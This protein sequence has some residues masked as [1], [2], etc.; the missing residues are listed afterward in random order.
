M[1]RL[2]SFFDDGFQYKYYYVYVMYIEYQILC[3]SII[4]FADL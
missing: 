1:L 2:E 4:F 3:F